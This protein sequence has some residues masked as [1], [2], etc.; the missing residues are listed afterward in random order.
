MHNTKTLG[1]QYHVGEMSPSL[2]PF[3]VYMIK[4]HSLQRKVRQPAQTEEPVLIFGSKRTIKPIPSTEPQFVPFN[5]CLRLGHM[6]F[7]KFIM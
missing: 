2:F 1:I 4:I 3:L 6:I 7:A 5:N